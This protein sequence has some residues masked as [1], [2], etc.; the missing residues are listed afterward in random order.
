MKRI[1]LV[2]CNNFFASCERIFNP[3]LRNKPVVVLSSNDAC[4]IARSN[5]AKKLG[6]KMGE[7]LF[8]AKDIIKKHNVAVFSSNFT[9][10][11]DISSRVMQTLAKH[12]TDIEIYSIDEAFLYFPNYIGVFKS[13]EEECAYYKLYAHMVKNKIKQEIGIPVSIGIG[14]TKVLAKIANYLVKKDPQY[15]GV[16]DLTNH[17]QLDDLLKE[18]NVA[19][20]WGIGRRYSKFLQR[21]G[22]ATAY[23]FKNCDEKW[24]RKHMTIN[25][26]RTV[27]ELRGTFC[28]N[29]ED[30]VEPKKS[31][32]VSRM[33][34]KNVTDFTE[35]KE[36][37]AYH[38][39]AAAEKLRKQYAI[40]RVI[41]VFI[42]FSHHYDPQ[43]FYDS[44]TIELPI[45]T[46][47]TPTL[48]EYADKCLKRLYKK[49]LIYKKVGVT[50]SD[51]ESVA[52][53]QMTAFAPVPDIERQANV[54]HIIDTINTK[55]GRNKVFY[56]GTGINKE[57]KTKS[58]IKSASYT[59]NWNE[60][61]I[62][63]I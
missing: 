2:D 42:Y 31:L 63:K 44:C 7:P 13:A 20:I 43:R 62:I 41:T 45:H 46:A 33:F 58:A 48:I 6:I 26:L 40:G 27:L 24:V 23:D 10:Y 50:I 59:T 57:W 52:S 3:K 53:M 18:V 56:A 51:L 19:D 11:A 47:Y 29:L 54:M 5:E 32:T 39:S 36:G 28:L 55:M 12:S 16:C 9:L 61:L 60:L 17:S 15:N 38:V 34:G 8:K 4:I 14:P 22:I 49:G 37:V 21:R 30:I 35:L 1:I 25:G